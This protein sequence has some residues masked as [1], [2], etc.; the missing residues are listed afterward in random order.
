M[1]TEAEKAEQSRKI[2][3]LNDA[4]RKS[5]KGGTTTVTIGV[6]NLGRDTLIAI[7]DTIKYFDDF[8]HN[9]DPYNEHDFGSVHI[10]GYHCFWKISYYGKEMHEGSPDPSDETVTTRVMT[11]M[12][13]SEY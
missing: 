5:G 13:A 8:D 4:F 6:S 1:A 12:L 10:D 11:I 2:A 9:N 7:C 3:R